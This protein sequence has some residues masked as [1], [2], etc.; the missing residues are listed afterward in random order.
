MDVTES[1]NQALNVESSSAGKKKRKRVE[2]VSIATQEVNLAVSATSNNAS[3][4]RALV[5]DEGNFEQQPEVH[6]GAG[7]YA[8]PVFHGG[9]C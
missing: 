6:L 4:S 7:M 5:R 8:P 9:E 3:T 2:K 1:G